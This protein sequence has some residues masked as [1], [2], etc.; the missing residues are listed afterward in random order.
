MKKITILALLGLGLGGCA[1]QEGEPKADESTA[2]NHE[3]LTNNGGGSLGYECTTDGESSTTVCI[4]NPTAPIDTVEACG[5][6]FT[7]HCNR[8]GWPVHCHFPAGSAPSCDC[9][10]SEGY[11][12]HV[13]GGVIVVGPNN[14][15]AF[16]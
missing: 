9:G 4:C 15:R 3:A 10:S 6:G 14:G 11:R 2:E 12:P 1:M 8:M 7:I 13:G 5:D 16:R